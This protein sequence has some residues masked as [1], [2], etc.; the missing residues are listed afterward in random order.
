MPRSD[1][2]QRRP[3]L[4]NSCALAATAAEARFRINYPKQLTQ[5]SSVIALDS[6]ADAVVSRL[7]AQHWSSAHFLNYQA[8][9]VVN[10]QGTSRDGMLR[11]TDGSDVLLSDELAGANLV[12]MVASTNDGAEA[13]AVIGEGCAERGIMTTGVV[14]AEW[15]ALEEALASLRPYAMVIVVSRDEDDIQG[16]LS[17]LRA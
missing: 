13:A 8:P 15:G 17:A 3:T 5:P 7:S 11:A 9:I 1:V 10:G 6:G 14:L 4:L 12:V 16:I 2:H